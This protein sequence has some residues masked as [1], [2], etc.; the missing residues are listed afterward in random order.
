VG[1]FG[2]GAG[3]PLNSDPPVQGGLEKSKISGGGTNFVLLVHALPGPNKLRE[4]KPSI[5]LSLFRGIN[6]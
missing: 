2:I 3:T 1:F 4:A 6:N 5:L